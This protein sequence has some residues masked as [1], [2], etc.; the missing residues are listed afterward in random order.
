MGGIIRRVIYAAR[1]GFI[2]AT[3]VKNK[4]KRTPRK[5]LPSSCNQHRKIIARLMK[6]Q[7]RSLYWVEQ[8]AG[9]NRRHLGKFLNY[10]ENVSCDWLDK[11]YKALGRRIEIR[12]RMPEKKK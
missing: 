4:K 8:E 9:V 1:K 3:S 5:A 2:V 10:G 6:A 12:V 11:V 7:K